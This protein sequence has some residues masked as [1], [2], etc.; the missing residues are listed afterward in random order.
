[1]KVIPIP[2][3]YSY[4]YTTDLDCDSI[5]KYQG[6]PVQFNQTLV[7]TNKLTCSSKR[8]SL[9][10][11]IVSLHKLPWFGLTNGHFAFQESIWIH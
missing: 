5:K 4:R 9:D 8:Q 10:W 6:L 7:V 3:K 11:R 1:M 2:R